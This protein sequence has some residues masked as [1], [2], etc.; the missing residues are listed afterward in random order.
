MTRSRDHPVCTTTQRPP[1]ETEPTI[2]QLPPSAKLVYKTLEYEG[3]LTQKDLVEQ[4]R[5][6]TRTVRDAIRTLEDHEYVDERLYT[7]DARQRLYVLC[8]E[9]AGAK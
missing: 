5:L 4:T 7:S 9:D 1:P 6:P 8:S 3:A 2:E